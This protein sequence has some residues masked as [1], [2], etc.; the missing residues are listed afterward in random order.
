MT[1]DRLEHPKQDADVNSMMC[2]ERSTTTRAP[3]D[4]Q[5]ALIPERSGLFRAAT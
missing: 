3:V 1:H 5:T 2:C 4:N